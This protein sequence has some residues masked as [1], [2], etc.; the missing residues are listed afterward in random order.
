MRVY[1]CVLRQ[2]RSLDFVTL[3]GPNYQ[4]MVGFEEKMHLSLCIF[5]IKNMGARENLGF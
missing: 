1:K 5:L 3:T 4:Q 2:N